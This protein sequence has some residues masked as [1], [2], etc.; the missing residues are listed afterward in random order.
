MLVMRFESLKLVRLV[1]MF[2]ADLDEEDP[3]FIQMYPFYF[4]CTNPKP[5]KF[6]STLSVAEYKKQANA[7]HASGD[8]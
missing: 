7:M 8:V 2:I 6:H 3:F 5:I 4:N 1:E